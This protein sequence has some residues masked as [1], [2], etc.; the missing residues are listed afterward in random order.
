MLATPIQLD[1]SGKGAIAKIVRGNK[2][3]FEEIQFAILQNC[4]NEISSD[5]L[6]AAADNI[7][8]LLQN[9]SPGAQ[10]MIIERAGYKAIAQFMN[11]IAEKAVDAGQCE[12]SLEYTESDHDCR[13]TLDAM[14]PILTKNLFTRI[15]GG[16]RNISTDEF[17]LVLKV[18][19]PYVRLVLK[20]V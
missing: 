13:S 18:D 3:S 6:G 19:I 12:I 8:Q 15:R 1:F 17:G 4:L 9:M 5:R 16:R 7:R 2:H 10:L 11:E 20:R 14:P